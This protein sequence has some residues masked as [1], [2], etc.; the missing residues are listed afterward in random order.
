MDKTLTTLNQQ[1]TTSKMWLLAG[2]YISQFLGVGF[3]LSAVPAILRS[4]GVGLD[5]IGWIYGLGLIWSLKFLWAPLVDRYGSGRLGHYRSWLLVMQSLLVVFLLLAACYDIPQQLTVLAFIFAAISMASAT[6]DIAADALA[7]NLLSH[8]ERGLGN[9]IQASGGM[10]GNM[11]GGGLVLIAYQWL[12]WSGSMGVLALASALPLIQII[13]HKEAPAPA[14]SRQD[15]PGLKDLLTLFRRPGMLHWFGLLS[16]FY[17]GISMAY[18]L[19]NPM[20]V[21]LGWSLDKI[22]FTTN[23]LGSGFAILG[24]LL[25]GYCIHK[26][27]R[28]ISMLLSCT[29]TATAIVALMPLALGHHQTLNVYLGVALVMLGSGSASTVI[30]T[31]AMDKSKTNSAATDFTAQIAISTLLAFVA[32]GIGLGVAEQTGYLPVLSAAL[33]VAILAMLATVSYR[34]FGA[35]EAANPDQAYS[36]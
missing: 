8:K 2:L 32:S 3:I 12:G 4:E 27:G 35:V 11:I 6:Q 28:K 5:K 21:D 29:I 14:A 20:L 9:T 30:F 16:L 22:G 7:V 13:R 1:T 10:L 31:T 25:S 18:A 23:V 17:T 33:G 24:S 15:K 26:L 36:V 19:L 34:R